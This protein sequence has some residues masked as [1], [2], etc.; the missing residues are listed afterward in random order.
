MNRYIYIYH[1]G[2]LTVAAWWSFQF[3]IYIWLYMCVFQCM[4]INT[5]I[6]VFKY[7]KMYMCR[8]LCVFKKHT[9]CYTTYINIY[10]YNFTTSSSLY[11]RIYPP[12]QRPPVWAADFVFDAQFCRDDLATKSFLMHASQSFLIQFV[13]NNTCDLWIH[14]QNGQFG[15]SIFF[16]W[17]VL[18]L[19]LL[20]LFLLFGHNFSIITTHPPSHWVIFSP[21]VAHGF[22]CPPQFDSKSQW[23]S[24]CI[25]I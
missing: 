14:H 4:Y 11:H 9:K 21:I 3:Y 5:Q 10:I 12:F 19:L 22:A 18:L 7:I 25:K 2:S 6:D 20:L 16:S 17:L 23:L 15:C 24:H 8:Y 1:V 13:S